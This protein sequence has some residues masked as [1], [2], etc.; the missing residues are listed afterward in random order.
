MAAAVSYAGTGSG[1]LEWGSLEVCMA[2]GALVVW[3]KDIP[4]PD[5]DPGCSAQGSFATFGGTICPELEGFEDA[6]MSTF[7]PGR[8]RDSVGF[9]VQCQFY[10]PGAITLTAKVQYRATLPGRIALLL[11]L[12]NYYILRVYSVPVRPPFFFL[13]NAK[14]MAR[15]M[16]GAGRALVAEVDLCETTAYVTPC[17]LT[18]LLA[19]VEEEA[20]ANAVLP[21][22]N[23]Q[24][25]LNKH[26][27]KE[28]RRS[29]HNGNGGPRKKVEYDI[30]Y[31]CVDAAEG[32]TDPIFYCWMVDSQQRPAFGT[33]EGRQVKPQ[34]Y[35]RSLSKWRQKS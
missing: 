11:A 27:Y 33:C 8:S 22:E 24:P 9:T 5:A 23:R 17:R 35:N 21:P 20:F 13:C 7:Y 1:L 25:F 4:L 15:A 6:I 12:F 32:E 16:A 31:P 28:P 3:S 29:H 10:T 26:V 34:F 2:G 14:Q 18:C 30:D 19:Q